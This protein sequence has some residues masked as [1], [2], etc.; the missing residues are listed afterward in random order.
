MSIV[1]WCCWPGTEERRVWVVRDVGRRQYEWPCA[2]STAHRPCG[3][4]RASVQ[5]LFRR[6]VVRIAALGD[7]E[8]RE[9]LEA[10]RVDLRSAG[11]ER[12]PV[13]VELGHEED[14]SRGRVV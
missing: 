1:S 11:R 2:P 3:R 6:L 10:R 12:H 13:A 8:L 4:R 14:R 7:R 9:R 5:Q